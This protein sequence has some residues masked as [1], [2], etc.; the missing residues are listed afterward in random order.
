MLT[1]FGG[2]PNEY[3][4]Q[5]VYVNACFW[6]IYGIEVERHIKYIVHINL[7]VCIKSS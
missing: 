1:F 3:I 4:N 2:I 7:S 5:H 6:G